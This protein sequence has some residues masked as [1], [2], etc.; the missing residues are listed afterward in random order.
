MR[1]LIN[2]GAG[3]FVA[4][5][6]VGILF[7]IIAL[8][9]MILSPGSG[10][11]AGVIATTI[12][13][14]GLGVGYFLLMKKLGVW[15]EAAWYTMSGGRKTAV[16]LLAL[17]GILGGIEFI[18]ILALFGVFAGAAE[19]GARRAQ[20]RGSDRRFPWLALFRRSGSL[21][22]YWRSALYWRGFS[23]GA[24]QNV[25]RVSWPPWLC[26]R[27][28]QVVEKEDQMNPLRKPFGNA[29]TVV[30]GYVRRSS[31]MQKDNFS[32]DAQKRAISDGCAQRGLPAPI[33]YED[34]ERSARGEQIAK[35]PACAAAKLWGQKEGC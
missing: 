10:N 11:V 8:V 18:I 21:R 28:L 35:R 5:F 2:F 16:F 27:L 31:Q 1:K 7:A 34:D 22:R 20:F 30:A 15:N 6:V 24:W 13:S 19:K 29:S 9:G 26:L 32:I 33:F 23:A 12:V 3:F 25:I 4:E 14:A 17:P